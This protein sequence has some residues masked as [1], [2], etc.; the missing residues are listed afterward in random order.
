MNEDLKT[1]SCLVSMETSGNW[2]WLLNSEKVESEGTIMKN[3]PLYTLKL[4]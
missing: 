2:H 4:N 3:V 1:A